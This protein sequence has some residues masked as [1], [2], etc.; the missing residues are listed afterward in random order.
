MLVI[1]IFVLLPRSQY[2]VALVCISVF[3]ASNSAGISMFDLNRLELG[4]IL[5][6]ESGRCGGSD[7][8]VTP[9]VGSSSMQRVIPNS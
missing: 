2:H 1:I 3:N 6:L 5:E 4:A 7:G 9:R 8:S